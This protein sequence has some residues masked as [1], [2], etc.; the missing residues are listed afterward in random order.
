MI[1]TSEHSNSKRDIKPGSQ[2]DKTGLDD[3][4]KCKFG[5]LFSIIKTI[6]VLNMF[7]ELSL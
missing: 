3:L 2:D 6:P 7:I 1:R 5:S 4:I